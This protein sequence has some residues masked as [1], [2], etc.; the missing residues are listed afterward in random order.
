MCAKCKLMCGKIAAVL[1]W[2]LVLFTSAAT[3]FERSGLLEIHYIN[4]GQGGSTLIVGPDGTRI[5]YDFGNV[6][7]GDNI[8]EYLK[9]QVGLEPED[10]IHFTFV[11]HRDA[12]HYG[13]YVDV[14]EAG[15]DI[16]IANFDS[17]SD[18]VATARMKKVW[19]TPAADTTAGEVMR[20]PV[21]LRIPIGDGAEVLVVAANGKVL[22]VDDDDLPFA[23]NENDRSIA[24]YVKYKDFDYVLDGDLGDGEDDCTDRDTSQKKLQTPVARVLQN[25]DNGITKENGIDV[26]HIAHHG[27]ESSTS[28]GY[29]S[30]LRPEV[31]LISVGLNQGTF[32]HPRV[33]VVEGVLLA[34]THRKSCVEA[35]PLLALFQTDYGKKGSSATGETS[36]MGMPIGDIKLT[37]DGVTDYKINGT[38]RLENDDDVACQ[39]TSDGGWTFTLPEAVHSES[40]KSINQLCLEDQAICQCV[41]SPAGVSD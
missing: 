24:L 31:G 36:F 15:Y 38:G 18:K 21:G 7:R 23:R 40:E 29:Y 27:S 28:S 9:N 10:G 35:N 26:L 3:A 19:L 11:S 4:V 33:D 13:G 14:I 20:V 2:T 8:G 17:G 34:G 5:L 32:R 41:L 16:L 39:P 12:D 30:I 1:L 37:T 25:L 22:G 6:G